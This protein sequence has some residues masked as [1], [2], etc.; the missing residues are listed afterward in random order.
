M[1]QVNRR[2][3][4]RTAVVGGAVPSAARSGSESNRTAAATTRPT[5]RFW[6]LPLLQ[7]RSQGNSYVACTRNGKVIVV[8]GGVGGEAGYLRGFLG[9]LGNDVEA[10]FISH[11]HPDHIGALNDILEKPEGIQIRTIFHSELSAAFLELE[12]DYMGLARTFYGNLRN[13]PA[14]VTDLAHPGLKIEIDGLAVQVL[15]VRNEEI[16]VNPYNNS[17]MVIRFEDGARS[18][19]LLGDIGQEAGDK[20]LQSEF[21]PQLDCDFLQMAHH[22]Q[23]GANKRFYQTIKFKTALWPT[24]LWLWNNDAGKGYNTGPWETIETRAWMDEIGI[25][26]HTVAAFGLRLVE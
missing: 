22:G 6:Q 10:W 18:F 24:P 16:G 11:P 25:G 3:F 23:R 14:K 5:S 19:V 20:L 7:T 4:M 26:Y 13:S 21:R 8:D 12:P 9:A 2:T 17:S 1:K 15:A